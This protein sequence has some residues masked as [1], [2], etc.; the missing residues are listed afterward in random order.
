MDKI[1]TDLL[2]L[3]NDDKLKKLNFRIIYRFLSLRI[4]FI[5]LFH[6]LSPFHKFHSAL[7]LSVSQTLFPL[8][9][10]S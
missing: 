9:V 3:K 8:P 1:V 5:K 7:A 2:D 10:L 4:A 6:M